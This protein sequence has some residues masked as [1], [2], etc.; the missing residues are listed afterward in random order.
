MQK[1]TRTLFIRTEQTGAALVPHERM[2]KQ[3]LGLVV[4]KQINQHT[5]LPEAY[6]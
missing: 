1:Y 2:V 3:R 6:P 4:L 5:G